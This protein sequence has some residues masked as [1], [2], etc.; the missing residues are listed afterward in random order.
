MLV[1]TSSKMIVVGD[2]LA[3]S[4]PKALITAQIVDPAKRYDVFIEES[5]PKGKAGKIKKTSGSTSHMSTYSKKSK[6]KLYDLKSYKNSPGVD[7]LPQE[8]HQNRV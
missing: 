6:N 2:S 7:V 5:I 4:I 3:F 8:K 1:R